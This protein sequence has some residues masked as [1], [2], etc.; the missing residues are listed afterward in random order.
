MREIGQKRTV[1][2]DEAHGSL[3]DKS[4]HYSGT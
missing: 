2:G 1:R 4:P 3:L